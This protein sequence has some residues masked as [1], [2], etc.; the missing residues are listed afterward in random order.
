M[1]FEELRLKK[2]MVNQLK[3]KHFC[4]FF[5]IQLNKAKENDKKNDNL[6]ARY[7]IGFIIRNDRLPM[8]YLHTKFR[9]ISTCGC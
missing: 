2:R 3:Y 7:D 8:I 1:H 6:Q 4:N 9:R 5:G